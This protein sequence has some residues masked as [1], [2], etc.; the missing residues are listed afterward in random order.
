MIWRATLGSL[1]SRSR[2]VLWIDAQAAGAADRAAQCHFDAFG[3]GGK[4]VSPSSE[5]KTAPPIRAAPHKPVRIVPQN[6]CNGNPAAVDQAAGAAVDRKRRLVA[7]I[8]GLGLKPPICA[9]QLCRLVQDRCPPHS[10]RDRKALCG[11]QPRL[12]PDNRI[13]RVRDQARLKRNRRQMPPANPAASGRSDGRDQSTMFSCRSP[14]IAHSPTRIVQ[15]RRRNV[16]AVR[17][18]DRI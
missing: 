5:A 2:S 13:A 15:E 14:G 16:A 1:S 7:E 9:A 4:L 8:N 12:P 17:R 11:A 3:G 10:R 6:H 18:K